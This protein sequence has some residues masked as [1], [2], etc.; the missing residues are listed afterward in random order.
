MLMVRLAQ[1]TNMPVRNTAVHGLSITLLLITSDIIA[2]PE[3]APKME[4]CTPSN[5]I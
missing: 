3:A 4:A 1:T 5:S 2:F